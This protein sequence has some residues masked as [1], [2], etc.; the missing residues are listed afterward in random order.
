MNF[1]EKANFRSDIISSL[2]KSV[3]EILKKLIIDNQSLVL[4]NINYLKDLGI[5]NY[6]EIFIKY[7][8]TFLLDFST[9]SS[10]FEKYETAD[11][12][13]KINKNIDVIEL[14]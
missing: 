10:I 5:N 8:D 12:I 1:L 14:L 2:N 11:L 6:E 7:Y 4:V 9:F 3:P 13:G